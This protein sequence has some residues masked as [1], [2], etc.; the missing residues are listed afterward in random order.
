M[1]PL[2]ELEQK[3]LAK[4]VYTTKGNNPAFGRNG[5]VLVTEAFERAHPDITARVRPVQPGDEPLRLRETL[6]RT[7][8]LG[9]ADTSAES[10]SVR[11]G[12]SPSQNGMVGGV[13]P[14]S[15][16]RTTPA[17]TLRICQEWV[18]SRKMSPAIDSIAQ[19]SLTVPTAMSSGS[20]TT[21]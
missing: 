6:V 3:G 7:L 13:V 4:V 16:T 5:H 12:A 2:I 15:R 18:P 10:S 17:S 8:T 11:A 9:S 19:S 1:T 21:R 20:A 14:A